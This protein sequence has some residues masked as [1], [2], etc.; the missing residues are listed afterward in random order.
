GAGVAVERN[1]LRRSASPAVGAASRA[2][3]NA[4]AT[5]GAA[6]EGPDFSAK[7]P[8]GTD[9]TV[10]VPGAPG[11]GPATAGEEV[12]TRPPGSVAP[13]RMAGAAQAGKAM[14]VGLEWLPDATVTA[15]PRL[16]S[17]WMA[18]S[19]LGSSPAHGTG[20]VVS[21]PRLMLTAAKW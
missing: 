19:T 3:A 6:I 10:R 18:A 2:S 14:P 1:R 16:D 17:C 11:L 13:A 4:P 12:A 7:A 20:N 15:I 5:A 21:P 9:G 8:P